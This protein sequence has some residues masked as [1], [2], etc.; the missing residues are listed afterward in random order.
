[1]QEIQA[2]EGLPASS[3]HGFI[4]N[5]T[6]EVVGGKSSVVELFAGTCRLSRAIHRHLC[7][8]QMENL[9]EVECFEIARSIQEDLLKEDGCS[10]GCISFNFD[11]SSDC[12]SDVRLSSR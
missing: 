2:L 7:E 12:S 8:K 3:Q 11:R 1:M 6:A 9:V 10:D 5:P 4:L